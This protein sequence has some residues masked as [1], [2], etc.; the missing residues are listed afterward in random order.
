MAEQQV[1]DPLFDYKLYRYG[2]S[3][4][5]FRGPQPDLRGGYLCFLGGSNTFGRFTDMPYS[6]EVGDRMRLTPLNLGTEGAGPGFFLSDPEVLRAAS[7]AK[8]CVIQVMCA[9]A[10]SNRMFS[11]RPRRNTRIHAVSD[12]LV[13]IYPEVDFSRFSFVHAMLKYLRNLDENRFKLISNEMKNAW[14]GRT[15]TL[16]S[17]IETKTVLFWFSQRSPDDPNGNLGGAADYPHFVDRS[18]IDSVVPSA[19]SYV[20]CVTT[21][22]LPQSL[23]IDGKTVLYRPSGEPL[24]ENRDL[25]SPEMHTAAAEVL[26][27]SIQQ[28]V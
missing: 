20:E 22:G 3:R 11:V 19:D 15:Q 21:Q 13:G 23:M 8:V 14:I 17:A 1:D 2:R 25:P 4:Q 26:I 24:N 12:L 10:L 5:V 28:L 16:L 18:M 9:S 27:P 7:D 6:H